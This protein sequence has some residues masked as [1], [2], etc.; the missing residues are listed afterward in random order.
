MNQAKQITEQA[1]LS[2][3]K[4]KTPLSPEDLDKAWFE[5]AYSEI[6]AEAKNL[7]EIKLSKPGNPVSNLMLKLASIVNGASNRGYVSPQTALADFMTAYPYRKVGANRYGDTNPD[8]AFLYQWSRHLKRATPRQRP[9]AAADVNHQATSAPGDSHVV[10]GATVNHRGAA[11]IGDSHKANGASVKRPGAAAAAISHPRPTTS[12]EKTRT[13]YDPDGVKQALVIPL[14]PKTEDYKRVITWL[15]FSFRRNEMGN[16]IEVNG[17]K[18]DDDIEAMLRNKF[19]D[20]G[21][22]KSVIQDVYREM[23]LNNSYH[24]IKDYLNGLTWDGTDYIT[25]LVNE[26]LTETTDFG[27]IA[28]T[29]W[30]IGCIAKLFD[31]AQNFMLVMDG[32]QGIGK[33][34]LARWLCPLPKYFVEGEL[35]P[36]NNDH[37]IRSMSKWI[38]EVGELQATTR[39]ADREALKGFISEQVVTVRKPYAKHDVEALMLANFIGTINE[40]GS[41][42]LSDPTGNR[43]FVTVYLAKIKHAYS[44]EIDVNQLW[45][46]AMHLYK[47]GVTNILEPQEELRRDEINKGYETSNPLTEMFFVYYDIDKTYNQARTA[48]SII[49]RLESMGLRTNQV[50]NLKDLAELMKKNGISQFNPRDPITK[51]QHRSYIGIVEK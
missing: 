3:A 23:A 22:P 30:M 9:A 50:Q 12:E 46:Q 1:P 43:R 20:Y 17:T 44:K 15:G 21:L 35:R 2:G 40:T 45:A 13:L 37:K 34:H 6:L 10:N 32:P 24:P 42:F 5:K 41:G 26:Y 7:P 38:W 31:G 47:Q 14:Q 16:I 8:K 28:F 49:L 27:V 39:K 11:A 33:S 18:I 36:D 51:K 29:R 19:G 48:I 4:H 25:I